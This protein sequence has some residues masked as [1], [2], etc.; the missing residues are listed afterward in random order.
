MCEPQSSEA[1]AVID[2]LFGVRRKQ[3]ARGRAPG[4]SPVTRAISCTVSSENGRGAREVEGV[5]EDRARVTEGSNI[6]SSESMF[7]LERSR[8]TVRGVNRSDSS[9]FADL[10]GDPR[11]V[12]GRTRRCSSGFGRLAPHLRHGLSGSCG[13][14]ANRPR[15]RQAPCE[16]KEPVIL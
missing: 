10:F 9:G 14:A 11:D 8:G 2:K 6:T 16:R 7:N 15:S 13:K 3:R 4:R 12:D 5:P 1:G